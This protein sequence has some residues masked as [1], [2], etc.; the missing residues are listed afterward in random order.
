MTVGDI[1]TEGSEVS[2]IL[3]GGNIFI[4]SGNKELSGNIGCDENCVLLYW[5]NGFMECNI[6]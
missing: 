3:L 2:V 6:F 4:L 5:E 1:V